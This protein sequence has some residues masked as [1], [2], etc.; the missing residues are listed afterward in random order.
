M[1]KTTHKLKELRI[2]LGFT[3]TELAEALGGEDEGWYFQR[4][5]RLEASARNP[6]KGTKLTMDVAREIVRKLKR[7]LSD[8][9]PDQENALIE[10]INRLE[11]Q[12]KLM[13]E[14]FV[15]SLLQKKNAD[16]KE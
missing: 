3:Q 1:A 11:A 7:P 6:D 4:I 2:E 12:E 14:T 15:Q 10:K 5:Q 13:L 8:L 16:R 9:I